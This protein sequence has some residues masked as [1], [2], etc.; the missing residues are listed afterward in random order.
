MLNCVL[1]SPDLLSLCSIITI[2]IALH[3]TTQTNNNPYFYIYIYIYNTSTIHLQAINDRADKLGK[4]YG[5]RMNTLAFLRSPVGEGDSEQ[6]LSDEE[7]DVEDN[8]NNGNNGN[9]GNKGSKGTSSSSNVVSPEQDKDKENNGGG[10]EKVIYFSDSDSDS[11]S[12]SD[13][14]SDAS[15][16]GESEDMENANTNTNNSK[17]KNKNKNKTIAVVESSVLNKRATDGSVVQQKIDLRKKKLRLAMYAHKCKSPTKKEREYAKLKQQV[18]NKAKESYCRRIKISVDYLSVQKE[19]SEKCNTLVNLLLERQKREEQVDKL[20]QDR[21]RLANKHLYAENADESDD[22]FDFDGDPSSS[23]S[24]SGVNKDKDGNRKRASRNAFAVRDLSDLSPEEREQFELEEKRLAEVMDQEEE[25]EEEEEVIPMPISEIS[26]VSEE[27]TEAQMEGVGVIP[28]GGEVH[29]LHS[30][31]DKDTSDI[32]ISASASSPSADADSGSGSG[33]QGSPTLSEIDTMPQSSIHTT[34]ITTSTLNLNLKENDDDDDEED[35]ENV[36]QKRPQAAAAALLAARDEIAEKQDKK[37]K[38]N[39]KDKDGKSDYER[40]LE[41]EERFAKSDKA[42]NRF[43]EL[44]A[45]EEEE[46][47]LQAGLGDFGFGGANARQND[48]ERNALKATKEDMNWLRKNVVNEL[49]EEELANMDEEEASRYRAQRQ[50]EDDVAQDK[51]LAALVTGQGGRNNGNRKGQM[52]LESLKRDMNGTH[53]A[54]QAGQDDEDYDLEEELQKGMAD[55]KDRERDNNLKTADSDSDSDASDEEDDLLEGATEE[56]RRALSNKRDLRKKE[57]RAAKLLDKQH[58]EHMKHKQTL[59]RQRSKMTRQSSILQS[60]GSGNGSQSQSQS[61]GLGS[62]Q[63]QNAAFDDDD[64]PPPVALA[65]SRQ[66]SNLSHVS[67][68]SLSGK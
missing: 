52:S 51:K 66:N 14:A 50:Q 13:D 64:L 68:G 54:A 20:K 46:T 28:K 43:L 5:Y 4:N 35:D 22:E 44:D 42:S 12:N 34:S 59:R 2:T 39:K 61:Q 1:E 55:R 30:S 60:N 53:E 7:S 18:A 58:K 17:D 47:G 27:A 10:G 62:F 3:I 38:K 15:S 8:G 45:E 31:K 19:I 56:E 6:E 48:E 65:L 63:I 26:E 32:D 37:D 29:Y 21:K 11:G 57:K 33:G 24:G 40:M 36:Y 25:E 49:D 16:D 67:H 23:S 9:S 41:A